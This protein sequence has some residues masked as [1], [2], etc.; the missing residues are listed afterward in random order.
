MRLYD[1]ASSE[2]Q[3]NGFCSS[4][5]PIRS[6]I[7]QG[8]PLS[9]LLFALCLNPLLHALGDVL[10]GIK[11]GRDNTKIAV[12]SYADDVTV[13]LTSP[14]DSQKLQEILSTY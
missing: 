10:S 1:G 9:M 11:I 7:K 12:A 14:V 8:C 13:F 2:V 3:I 5:F 6:A 4:L